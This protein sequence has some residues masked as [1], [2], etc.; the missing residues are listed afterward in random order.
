[1]WIYGPSNWDSSCNPQG[2]IRS[3]FGCLLFWIYLCLVDQ[4]CLVCLQ[5][6]WTVPLT[7]SVWK[8]KITYFQTVQAHGINIW[9]KEDATHVLGLHN[10]CHRNNLDYCAGYQQHMHQL[11]PSI[12][13]NNDTQVH[14][15]MG[16][17]HAK[18]RPHPL[19]QLLNTLLSLINPLLLPKGHHNLGLL[20]M[21]SFFFQ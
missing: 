18:R 1:M 2:W 3:N 21:L 9:Q 15:G 19:K 13:A 12:S 7:E 17:E 16:K 8:I 5:H 6:W 4:E 11:K 20:G 10:S 14:L